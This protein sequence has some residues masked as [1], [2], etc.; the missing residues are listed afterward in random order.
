MKL[1]KRNI[2]IYSAIIIVLVVGVVVWNSNGYTSG[3]K[4]ENTLAAV[5]E[6]KIM[7]K[8]QS[9]KT[10][11]KT[12]SLTYK[13]TLE[14]SEYG[15]VSSKLSGKVVGILCENGE[16]VSKGEPLVKMD[17][18]DI[19]NSIAS[20][21]AQLAVAETQLKS[22]QN[23]LLYAQTGLHKLEI[24]LEN[25]QINYDRTKALFDEGGAAKVALENAESSLKTAKSDL[26]SMKVNIE[27]S[28]LTVE[29]AKAS[30]NSV[31]VN[32]STLNDSLSNTIIRAPMRGVIDEKSISIGQFISAGMVLAKVKNVSN[33]NAVI[34]I[35][36]NNL[37][38]VK[39]GMKA[40][41][42]LN[43]IGSQTYEG[44]MKNI[45][46][47]AD[48]AARVFSCKI[49]VDN[50]NGSLHPGMFATVELINDQK[51]EALVVPIQALSG[52]EG[53][54]SVFV[55]QDDKAHKRSVSVGEI[56]NDTAEILSGLQK[57]E[58]LIITN[59]NILQDGDAVSIS[60]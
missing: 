21:K 34:Q 16:A 4:K 23:Q 19:K 24:N 1:T 29:T 12:T 55:V 32:I 2:S 13:A 36:Q 14:P 35:E 15:I 47:S 58:R 49:Q 53:D 56:A 59:L 9:V 30:V 43:D 44:T 48:A 33:L 8:T 45:N 51:H 28:R 57:D 26:E 5:S 39:E 41:I 25:T 52:S 3:I 42:K 31:E 60:E 40:K 11:Q 50:E 46:M 37:K 27:S 22:S 38:Y 7:V 18:K 20:A 6:N 10:M 17:D 54:Y